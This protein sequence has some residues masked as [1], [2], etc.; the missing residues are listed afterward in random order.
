MKKKVE[1]VA[2]AMFA[3]WN[4]E[5]NPT[6]VAMNASA[7]INVTFAEIDDENDNDNGSDVE[8]VVISAFEGAV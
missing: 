8:E 3:Q 1:N 7:D 6:Q 2:E 5:M 4:G